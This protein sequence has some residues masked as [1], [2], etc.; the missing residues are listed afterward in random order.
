M[1]PLNPNS[2]RITQQ[3]TSPPTVKALH[4]DLLGHLL[5]DRSRNGVGTI[6]TRPRLGS[7]LQLIL[8]GRTT[9][10]P[11]LPLVS[12]ASRC[13][14]MHKTPEALDTNSDP[15]IPVGNPE[16]GP[17]TIRNYQN[18]VPTPLC[19]QVLRSPPDN[20]LRHGSILNERCPYQKPHFR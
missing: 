14:T 13:P 19:G 18:S 15:S 5:A 11:R 8:S 12:R 3:Q 6:L 17:A 1:S 10:V 20:T 2:H 7:P 9:V 4:P 16:G